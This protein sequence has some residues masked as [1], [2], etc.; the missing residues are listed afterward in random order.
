KV[1]V[2]DDPEVVAQLF[3]K[4]RSIVLP[5]VDDL[6]VILGVITIDDVVNVVVEEATEDMLKLS[7]TL[8]ED[9]QNE[10]LIEGA[11]W[12]PLLYRLPWLFVTILGGIIASGI[13][14]RY[15]TQLSQY[16]VSLPFVLSFVPLLMGLGGNIGNQ[17]ATILVRALAVKPMDRSQRVW[18]IGRELGVGCVI[19]GVIAGV[20]AMYV[21][22]VSNDLIM[23]LCLAISIVLNMGLASLLGA[24]LPI[25]L[26]AC[27]IDPAIASAPFISTTLDIIGQLIYFT[28][29]IM[30]FAWVL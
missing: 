16:P 12:Y 28:T 2:H 23:T 5:V 17:S 8:G 15:S 1:H 14:L 9:I 26:K 30:L 11:L 29:I 10:K 24:S 22:G 20:V 19:G 13:M 25:L 7:G 3:Q 4:F 21:Y 27:R 18:V 6:G